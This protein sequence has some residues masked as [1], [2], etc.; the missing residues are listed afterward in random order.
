MPAVSI[1]KGSKQMAAISL[2]QAS[3]IADQI[4]SDKQ[5]EMALNAFIAEGG[6]VVGPYFTDVV[7]YGNSRKI[8]VWGLVNLGRQALMTPSGFEV[9]FNTCKTELTA[10][11]KWVPMK[12]VYVDFEASLTSGQWKE[13]YGG[14]IPAKLTADQTTALARIGGPLGFKTYVDGGKQ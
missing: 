6:D 14:E 3:E 2:K 9:A 12:R 5:I 10:D 1:L 4:E 8:T 7:A 13:L 11:P